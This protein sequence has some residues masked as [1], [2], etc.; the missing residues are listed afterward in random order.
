[1]IRAFY[2]SEEWALWAYGGLALLISSLW[3]QVQLTVAI[4]TW[5]GGFYDHLQKAADFADDPQE[6]ID[7]FYDFLIST[8][9][10]VNGFE[11]QPSRIEGSRRQATDRAVIIG[12]CGGADWQGRGGSCPERK[13]AQKRSARVAERVGAAARRARA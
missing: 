8:D 2:K 6:G 12:Y 7:I 13:G 5:Y 3:V 4:N 10:L 11:G 9:Y 1:M